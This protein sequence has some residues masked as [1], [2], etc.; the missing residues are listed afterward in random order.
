[1]SQIF[2]LRGSFSISVYIQCIWQKLSKSNFCDEERFIKLFGLC[3]SPYPRLKKQYGRRPL[4]L[5]SQCSNSFIWCLLRGDANLHCCFRL[6]FSVLC[7][8]ICAICSTSLAVITSGNYL[9]SL[10]YHACCRFQTVKKS[11]KNIVIK[12]TFAKDT[13]SHCDTAHERN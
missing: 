12:L 6:L 3:S 1:M 5:T 7:H 8:L 11:I 4:A 9:L 10:C 2:L 13:F